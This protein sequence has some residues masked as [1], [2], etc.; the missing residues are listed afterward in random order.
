MKK[1]RFEFATRIYG[2]YAYVLNLSELQMEG[3]T[4]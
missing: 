4:L 2:N 1:K 3:K